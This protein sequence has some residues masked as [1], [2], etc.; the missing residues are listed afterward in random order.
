MCVGES[1]ADTLDGT[2]QAFLQ[3]ATLRHL[4]GYGA[5]AH[6]NEDFIAWTVLAP[7]V[8][9]M[10]RFTICRIDP[11]LIVMVEDATSWR[12]FSSAASLDDAV[13]FVRRTVSEAAGALRNVHAAPALAQ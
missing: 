12:R 6:V 8:P 10:P 3:A 5:Q 4:P 7:D 11:S 9:T 13:A 2:E 1:A